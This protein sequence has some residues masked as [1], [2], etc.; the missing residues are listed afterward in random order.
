MYWLSLLVCSLCLWG[1][2]REVSANNN[3]SNID[4]SIKALKKIKLT[5]KNS[6]VLKG[7]VDDKSIS[8]LIHQLNKMEKKNEIYLY[9][10][11]PGGSVES[12]QKLIS[13]IL[14][15]NV[16]CIAEKAYSMGFA[17]LQSC[18]N[19]YI[20]RHGKLM[21]HQVQFGLGGELG[22][23][24]SYVNFIKQMEYEMTHVMAHRIGLELE[25]FKHKIVDE[26]WLYGTFAL[27]SNCADEM[28]YVECSKELTRQNY[29][30]TKGTHDLI[31]SKCPLVTNEIDKK[32][33]KTPDKQS[34]FFDFI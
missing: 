32:K 11:T 16:S 3:T 30:L 10:D 33:S 12:G 5:T 27:E 4:N 19:R 15:H 9:L 7:S 14:N 20:L 24:N 26:W 2:I 25:A 1:N 29:T 13:E 34:F 21:M 23:V 28:V 18:V 22:K 17:I 6:L 31:Y 8:T